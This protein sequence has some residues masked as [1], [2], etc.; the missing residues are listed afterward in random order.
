MK[1]LLT[2]ILEIY[3][4][5]NPL[6]PRP[7]LCLTRCKWKQAYSFLGIGYYKN[8]SIRADC[9]ASIGAMVVRF[10]EEAFGDK[11]SANT[12]GG[13]LEVA[14]IYKMSQLLFTEISFCYL[15][16]LRTRSRE[17]P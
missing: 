9:R 3:L 6:F 15:G 13:C 14:L 7:R 16:L 11:V 10:S 2:V 1:Y 5:S 8:L 12:M 4:V 17:Y